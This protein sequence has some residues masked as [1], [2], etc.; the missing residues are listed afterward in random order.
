MSGRGEGGRGAGC[1]RLVLSPWPSLA[2]GAVINGRAALPGPPSARVCGDGFAVRL[3]AR[4]DP[5]PAGAINGRRALRLGRR[6]KMRRWA[7]AGC[8]L[9]TA[10]A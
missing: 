10:V 6:D 3:P 7:P 5:G 9:D 8:P 2:A 4:A 1:R